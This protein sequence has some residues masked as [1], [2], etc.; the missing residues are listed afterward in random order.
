MPF[1][2]VSTNIRVVSLF[3]ANSATIL[4]ILFES[5]KHVEGGSYRTGLCVP[6]VIGHRA[7][8]CEWSLLAI[9]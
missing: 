9:Y 8:K 5:A 2:P 6:N 4:G 3:C 7:A 1:S